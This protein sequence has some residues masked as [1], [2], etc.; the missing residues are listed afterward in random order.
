MSCSALSTLPFHPFL[1]ISSVV[2]MSLISGKS[3]K[4]LLCYSSLFRCTV[5]IEAPCIHWSLYCLNHAVIDWQLRSLITLRLF[6]LQAASPST[7]PRRLQSEGDLAVREPGSAA[8]QVSDRHWRGDGREGFDVLPATT[9]GLP[10]WKH[11]WVAVFL[12]LTETE[13]VK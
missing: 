5:F 6:A 12:Q 3:D 9:A 10:D 1:Y 11:G 2:H 7:E 13:T 4:F 8:A